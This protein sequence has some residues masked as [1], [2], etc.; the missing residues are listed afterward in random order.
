MKI[1]TTNH[2]T[3]KCISPRVNNK[4]WLWRMG[5]LGAELSLSLC[6]ECASSHPGSVLFP[7]S[8]HIIK[9][10]TRL[11]NSLPDVHAG[12]YISNKF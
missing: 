3:D 7:L 11:L 1:M 12:K 2:I 5:H 10:F 9:L 8:S 4:S 6:S